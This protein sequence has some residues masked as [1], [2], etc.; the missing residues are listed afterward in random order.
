MLLESQ[1]ECQRAQSSDLSEGKVT[2]NEVYGENC[3]TASCR[4]EAG[5][6]S[7]NVA[8]NVTGATTVT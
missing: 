2:V 7:L 4:A 6:P 3:V 8:A 5:W 1:T